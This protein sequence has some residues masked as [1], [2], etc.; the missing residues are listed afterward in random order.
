MSLSKSEFL[1]YILELLS[2]QEAI[3]AKAM[4]GGYGI[5]KY[6]Q[7]FALI[8]QD[9]LYFKVDD[10]N[11]EYFINEGSE[12]FSYERNG[13]QCY[14]SYYN[15]PPAIYDNP[16]LLNSLVEGSYQISLKAAV[17]SSN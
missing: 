16:E 15:A 8:I 2:G 10:S 14:M 11:R 9:E 1:D 6:S 17:S 4:F 7:I 5:Y 13:K 12:P 3:S